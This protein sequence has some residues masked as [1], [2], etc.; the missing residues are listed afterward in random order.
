MLPPRTV[1]L[2]AN[3]RIL[4]SGNR[5]RAMA[6]VF[7]L[8]S[9]VGV[10]GCGDDNPVRPQPPAP[11]QYLA[12]TSP[13]NVLQNLVSAYVRRDSVQT[14]VVYNDGYAGV[15]TDP[16]HPSPIPAFSKSDEVRHIAR[17][18]TDPNIVLVELDLGSRSSWQRLPASPSDPPNWAVIQL[19]N[20]TVR[21]EDIGRATTWQATNNIMEFKFHPT[22]APPGDTTWTVI[23]WSEFAN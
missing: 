23:R 21:I 17:L 20:W 14:A 6:A 22:V 12:P 9:L 18:K 7:L 5:L 3:R 13:E 16:S 15:S 2:A 1:G 11:F 8:V 4:L 10:A 19:T